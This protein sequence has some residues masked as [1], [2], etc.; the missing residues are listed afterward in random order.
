MLILSLIELTRCNDN[1]TINDTYGLMGENVQSLKRL[2]RVRAVIPTATR[3]GGSVISIYISRISYTRHA[4][5]RAS[6][7]LYL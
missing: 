4:A 1:T 5:I 2:R 6:L 3:Y 7:T